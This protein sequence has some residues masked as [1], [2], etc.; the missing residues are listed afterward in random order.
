MRPIQSPTGL[1]TEHGEVFGE[2]TAVRRCHHRTRRR[3]GGLHEVAAHQW[4]SGSGAAVALDCGGEFWWTELAV[5]CS[6]STEGG[7]GG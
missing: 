6:Y 4:S 3:G 7:L 5:V 2:S 1:A